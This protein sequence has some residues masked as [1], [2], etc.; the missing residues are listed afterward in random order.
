MNSK[1]GIGLVG[2]ICGAIMPI[3]LVMVLKLSASRICIPGRLIAN[4]INVKSPF[5]IYTPTEIVEIYSVFFTILI[6]G[7]LF[8]MIFIGFNY[9]FGSRVQS[10]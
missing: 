7:I 5:T 1:F 4:L 6:Y 3:V 8:S 9:L 2:F 10:Q